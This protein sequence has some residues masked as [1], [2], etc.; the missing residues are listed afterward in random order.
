MPY[1]VKSKRPRLDEVKDQ[2]L[3]VLSEYQMD[4]EDD[5]LEGNLNYFISSIL[6]DLYNKNYGE[7][8]SAVGLLECIKQEF[9]QQMAV[10]YETKKEMLNGEVYSNKVKLQELMEIAQQLDQEK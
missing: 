2:L 9:Y 5:N 8:N 4:D 1:I 7:I 3:Q 10:P 6:N